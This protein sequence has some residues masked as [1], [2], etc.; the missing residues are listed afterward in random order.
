MK[1]SPEGTDIRVGL[2]PA[3]SNRWEILV[4][5]EGSG[6]PAAEHEKVFERF[7]RLGSELRRETQGA[8]IGLSIVAHIAEAH[9]GR[10]ELAS[11]PN[12]GATF[13][14]VFPVRPPGV[15]EAS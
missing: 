7:Y 9:G 15:V 3:S 13:T 12:K 8:G 14:L 4:R 11:E 10:V 6:I 1:F 2:R 5:D